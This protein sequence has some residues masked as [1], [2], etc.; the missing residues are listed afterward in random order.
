MPP[1]FELRKE[2]FSHADKSKLFQEST[3]SAFGAIGSML[4]KSSGEAPTVGGYVKRWGRSPA[5]KACSLHGTVVSKARLL[6]IIFDY[7]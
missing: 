7:T 1:C 5:Q 6:Y 4:Q 2:G 3:A